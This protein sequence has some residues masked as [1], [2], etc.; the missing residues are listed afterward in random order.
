MNHALTRIYE[1]KLT[2]GIMPVTTGADKEFNC[3]A[4]FIDL[5]N[6]GIE[7]HVPL[8]PVPF[9]IMEIQSNVWIRGSS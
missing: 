5:E 7:P 2:H 4:F 9:A 6:R 3:G 1:L 8:I